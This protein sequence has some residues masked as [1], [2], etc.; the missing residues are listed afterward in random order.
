LNVIIIDG[1]VEGNNYCVNFV[2][3]NI[4]VKIIYFI[5]YLFI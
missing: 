5:I 2:E 1:F 4:L 3:S